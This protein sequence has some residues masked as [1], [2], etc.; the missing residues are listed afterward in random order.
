VPSE[1][2]GSASARCRS[3]LLAIYLNDHLAAATGAGALARRAAASNRNS[4]YG[5]FLDQLAREI[6]DDRETLLAIMGALDVGVD[7][8]KVLSGYAAE[9]LG[10][11][12][13]NGRL[14]GYS[15]LSRVVELEVLALGVSGKQS[16]WRTLASVKADDRRLAEFDLSGLL[17]RAERQRNELESQ[18]IQ[19]AAEAFG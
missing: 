7:R 4:S 11:I 9:K 19:A 2:D 3:P 18:R 10:R 12:K 16:L 1:A 6:A 13:L 8:V 15:P 17:Q 5:S 14:F